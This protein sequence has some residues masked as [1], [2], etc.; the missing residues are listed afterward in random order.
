M[1]V[2]DEIESV[3]ISVCWLSDVLNEVVALQQQL[4]QMYSMRVVVHINVHV[5]VATDNDRT[6]V[7]RQL[8]ENCRQLFEKSHCQCLTA[9]SVD[10]K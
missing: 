4:R 1:P 8:V 9:R 2:D 6:L 5:E 7:R 10:A 3:T